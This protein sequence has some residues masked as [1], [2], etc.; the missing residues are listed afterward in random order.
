MPSSANSGADVRVSMLSAA[1]AMLVCGCLSVFLLRQNCASIA[2]TFTT[3][4]ASVGVRS[5]SGFS[6]L[7]RMN[8]AIAFTTGTSSSSGVGT[9][10]AVIRQRV[11]RGGGKASLT[12]EGV[13]LHGM[14]PYYQLYSREEA[15][16]E[17]VP[18]TAATG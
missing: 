10:D 3:W 12:P 11:V 13:A 4:R 18:L 8:G 6:L 16:T 14:A 15:A 1:L 7:T 2:E 5:M 17:V 9:S